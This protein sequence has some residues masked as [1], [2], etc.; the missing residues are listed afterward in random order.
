[1]HGNATVLVRK[2]SHD[3]FENCQSASLCSPRL[4]GPGA[5]EP[6]APGPVARGWLGIH[7]EEE[8]NLE[9]RAQDLNRMEFRLAGDPPCQPGKYRSDGL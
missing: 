1:V 2:V 3:P 8:F 4:P 9:G 5:G 7:S 6:S